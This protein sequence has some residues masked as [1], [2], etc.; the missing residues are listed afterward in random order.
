M[1]LIDREKLKASIRSMVE[2]PNEARA[3]VIGAIS[4][5]KGGWIPV[6]ERLPDNNM[7]CL[8]SYVFNEN[9]EYHFEQVLFYCA[10]CEN[11]HF[12]HEGELGLKVT[13]WMP[14]PEPP[15]GE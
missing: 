9:T 3:Q 8:C 6:T 13:H 11:P 15:K 2:L 10:T 7:K 1:E 4:R 12:Q 14:I 5:A